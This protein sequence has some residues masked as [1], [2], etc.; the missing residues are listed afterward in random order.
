[1]LPQRGYSKGNIV[2]SNLTF[3]L[4]ENSREIFF[5]HFGLWSPSFIVYLIAVLDLRTKPTFSG[6]LFF[7]IPKRERKSFQSKN[8][9]AFIFMVE[10]LL[11]A[12]FLLGESS[13]FILL[14]FSFKTQ[15]QN[16]MQKIFLF[17]L[18]SLLLESLPVA[19][20]K[21]PPHLEFDAKKNFFFHFSDKKNCQKSKQNAINENL[22]NQTFNVYTFKK[23]IT[24]V[25]RSP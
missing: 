23:R 3:I 19:K 21:I 18:S 11:F 7:P 14:D 9:L 22:A 16:M 17:C 25:F 5:K 12:A 13:I 24:L 15:N 1:M 8:M 2:K 4:N 6:A 10:K 20:K